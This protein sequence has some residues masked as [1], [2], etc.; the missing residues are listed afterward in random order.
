MVYDL[1]QWFQKKA[2]A[3]W[4][5]WI[6]SGFFG[7]IFFCPLILFSVLCLLISL[8]LF[9]ASFMTILENIARGLFFFFK[10][11]LSEAGFI[12]K[13]FYLPFFI[14]SILFCIGVIAFSLGAA[15][16]FKER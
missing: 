8:A 7:K 15:L 3:C 9:A 5:S 13:I 11:K 1:A 4:N 16:P 2:G 12:G 6:Q 14:A 10:R